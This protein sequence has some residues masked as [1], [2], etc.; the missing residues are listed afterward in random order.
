MPGPCSGKKFDINF[1][2]RLYYIGEFALFST[3][4]NRTIPGIVL[5]ETVLS[6]DPLVP[7]F[8]LKPNFSKLNN[9]TFDS[10]GRH[11]IE[12]KQDNRSLK[13]TAHLFNLT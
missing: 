10:N 12:K 5:S 6:R 2:N 9:L 13:K 8:L 7:G 4:L 1:G 3:I 11:A